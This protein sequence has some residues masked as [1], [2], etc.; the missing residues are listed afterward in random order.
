MMIFLSFILKFNPCIPIEQEVDGD[1]LLTLPLEK[2]A[3]CKELQYPVSKMTLGAY[4][5][6]QKVLK[7]VK[8]TVFLV[9]YIEF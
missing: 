5:K 3:L 9:T 1:T 4:N 2:D 8:G 7:E 6:L